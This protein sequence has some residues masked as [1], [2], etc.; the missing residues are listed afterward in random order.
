MN[1][2]NK[3]EQFIDPILNEKDYQLLDILWILS[4]SIPS[5]SGYHKN[6]VKLLQ[7]HEKTKSHPKNRS[8]HQF[9]LTV[10]KLISCTMITVAMHIPMIN[11]GSILRA[12]SSS[13]SK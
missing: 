8:Y 3:I 13:E 9:K 11:L 6:T 7:N 12:L 1:E 4:Y 2:K 5:T 10:R